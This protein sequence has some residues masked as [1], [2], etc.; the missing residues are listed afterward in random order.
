MERE[1]FSRAAAQRFRRRAQARPRRYVRH[2]RNRRRRSSRPGGAVAIWDAPKRRLLLVRDRLGIKPLYWCRTSD[3]LLF[4][5]EIKALLASGMIEAEPNY[6]VLPEMLSTRYTS[7]EDT[8]FKGVRKL[9][10]G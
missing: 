9:L 4:G 1:A 5:S 6:A 3:A 2:R 8:L 10:P 7:G